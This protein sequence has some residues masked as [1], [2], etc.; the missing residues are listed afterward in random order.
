MKI[1]AS[2]AGGTSGVARGSLSVAVRKTGTADGECGPPS[3]QHSGGAGGWSYL[4]PGHLHGVNGGLHG[5][6]H[7]VSASPGCGCRCCGKSVS[8]HPTFQRGRCC[9]PIRPSWTRWRVRPARRLPLCHGRRDGRSAASS[10]HWNVQ[11]AGRPPAPA[12]RS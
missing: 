7:R 11:A 2:R 1:G 10:G 9:I 6:M 4:K 5:S 3:E 8:E 12:R